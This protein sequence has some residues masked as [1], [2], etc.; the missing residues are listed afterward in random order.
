MR[1]SRSRSTIPNHTTFLLSPA[2]IAENTIDIPVLPGVSYPSM[3]DIVVE[4]YGVEKLLSKVKPSKAS[5]PDEIP[6]R[7]LKDR[8]GLRH[9]RSVRP[10]RAANFKGAA[11]FW[12]KF[13]YTLYNVLQ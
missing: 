12:M 5:G 9:V 10:H 8:A 6:C 1:Y 13:F 3:S 4:P 2:V 11:K 7:V